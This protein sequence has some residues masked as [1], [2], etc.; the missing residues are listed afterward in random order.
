LLPARGTTT[1]LPLIS[2]NE[3]LIHTF[4]SCSN[5]SSSHMPD[6]AH[7][8]APGFCQTAPNA[9]RFPCQAFCQPSSG[10]EELRLQHRRGMCP[11]GI[12]CPQAHTVGGVHQSPPSVTLQKTER[13]P[14]AQT[15]QTVPRGWSLPGPG[16]PEQTACKELFPLP[17]P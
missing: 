14:A 2:D 15:T 5:H 1:T 7:P 12:L 16:A 11:R 9:P 13:A 17:S 8:V 4:F 3:R 10:R 6:H